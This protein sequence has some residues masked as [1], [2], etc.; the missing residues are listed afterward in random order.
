MLRGCLY[1]FGPVYGTLKNVEGKA[2][3]EVHAEA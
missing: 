3:G 1:F 2:A